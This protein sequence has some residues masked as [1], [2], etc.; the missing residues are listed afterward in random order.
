MSASGSAVDGKKQTLTSRRLGV[1]IT[2]LVLVVIVL[3][4]L[5][6][7]SFDPA[8]A[9]AAAG[10]PSEIYVKTLLPPQATCGVGAQRVALVAPPVHLALALASVVG[11][12]LV[13]PICRRQ[14]AAKPGRWI[15]FGIVPAIVAGCCLFGFISNVA[16]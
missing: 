2:V 10:R 1:L 4:Y 13:L 16:V 8:S 3:I 11:L 15:V 7:P 6:L 12:I 9:C 5:S 14:R